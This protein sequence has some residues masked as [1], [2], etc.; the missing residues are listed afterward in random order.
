MLRMSEQM[1]KISNYVGVFVLGIVVLIFFLVAI[2]AAIQMFI[3]IYR[4]L[5][6]VKV[7]KT[8]SCRTCGRSISSTALICPDCGENYGELHGAGDSIVMCFF[9][10][11]VFFAIGVAAL[12]ESVGWFERTFLN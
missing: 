2:V 9:L 4:K 1:N 12:T 7:S 8:R 10:A 6:G 3:N 11:L 5:R